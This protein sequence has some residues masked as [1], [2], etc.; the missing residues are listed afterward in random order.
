MTRCDHHVIWLQAFHNFNPAWA[1]NAHL[2]LGALRD[3]DRISSVAVVDH[4]D[5][6]NFSTLRNNG[7]FWNHAGLI[8]LS[9]HGSHTGK[10]ARAQRELAVVNATPH[11]NG[12]AVGINEWVD[13]QH[14][15]LKLASGQCIQ[16][17]SSF[18]AFSQAGLKPFWQPVIDKHGV[19]VL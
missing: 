3:L 15:R 5:H 2:D 17:H 9:K 19:N 1:A 10:H 6:K 7:F 8:A 4:L 12:A 14:H 16:V 11:P 18:L 13:G